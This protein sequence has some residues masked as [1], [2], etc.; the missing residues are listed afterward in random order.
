MK[1]PI[2]QAILDRWTTGQAEMIRVDSNYTEGEEIDPEW[3]FRTPEEMP[4]LEIKALELCRGRILDVGAGAGCHALELQKAGFAITAVEQSESSVRV[5]R[6]RGV[7]RVVCADIL[8]FYEIG[9]DTILLLMNG[10]G[11]AGSLDGLRKL[12][13]HLKTL[14][15]PTGQILLDSSDIHYLF[16]EEDGSVWIDLARD[17]YY[18]EMSYEVSYKGVKSDPFPWLFIDYDLLSDIA[19]E[20]GFQCEL[21]AEGENDDY[22]ARLTLA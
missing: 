9:W 20:S 7:S 18:G 22:L 1:D 10:S 14:L 6:E 5:M 11:I 16:E 12:L 17:E 4:P 13:R 15:K 3:F 8:Q 2:G 21:A 19:R